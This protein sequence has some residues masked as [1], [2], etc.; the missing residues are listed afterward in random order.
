MLREKIFLKKILSLARKKRRTNLVD[1][2]MLQKIKWV[3][4]SGNINISKHSNCD[5]DRYYEPK[6]LKEFGGITKGWAP[7]VLKIMNWVK[8]K[9]RTGKVEHCAKFLEEE[10]FSFQLAISTFD[11]ESDIPLD[12]VV[13]LDQTPVSYVSLGKCTF[14]LKGPIKVPIKRVGDKRQIT[15]TF[16]VSASDSL[17]PIQ[18]IYNDKTKHFLPK[19]DFSKIALTLYSLQIIVPILKY[20][21]SC[22]KKIKANKEEL[23]YPKKQYSLIVMDTFK[24]Q[25]NAEMK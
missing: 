25:D 10:K 21:S 13:N 18:L 4:F 1:D 20:V 8:R 12:F 9:G 6:I 19:L 11:S 3:T 2:E 14:D 16:T 22:L 17:F 7:N 15:A 24:G 5:R 23:G